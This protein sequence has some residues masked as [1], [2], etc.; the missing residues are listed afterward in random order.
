MEEKQKQYISRIQLIDGTT[1]EVKDSEA[2]ST[3]EH[4]F[5]DTIILDCGTS[6]VVVDQP[7]NTDL[8][9]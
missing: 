5:I 6:T 7:D 8:S 3:L 1:R 2:R 4:L 9:E